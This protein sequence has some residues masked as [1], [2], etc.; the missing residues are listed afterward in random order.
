MIE[1]IFKVALLIPIIGFLALFFLWPVNDKDPT[2]ENFFWWI[3]SVI[4][5]ICWMFDL[6]KVERLV[7]FA[8]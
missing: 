4:F 1:L 8:P 7:L 6:L 2:F 5:T 3:I